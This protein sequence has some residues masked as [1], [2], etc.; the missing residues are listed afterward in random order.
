MA[1]LLSQVSKWHFIHINSTVNPKKTYGLKVSWMIKNIFLQSGFYCCQI[2]SCLK[3]RCEDLSQVTLLRF[4]KHKCSQNKCPIS[5]EM[6]I[7]NS[8][9]PMLEY[10]DPFSHILAEWIHFFIISKMLESWFEDVRVLWA[11]SRVIK[12]EKWSKIGVKII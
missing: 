7:L 5:W 9:W 11:H 12:P 4:G 10:H 3:L 8:Y 2:D 1:S 6:R